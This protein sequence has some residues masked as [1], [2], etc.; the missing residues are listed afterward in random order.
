MKNIIYLSCLFLLLATAC[1]EDD[2]FEGDNSAPEPFQVTVTSRGPATADLEWNATTDPDGDSITYAVEISGRKVISG[3]KTN[4]YKLTGL[5][6]DS[7]YNGHVVAIDKRGAYTPAGF[8]ILPTPDRIL[9]TTG[10]YIDG[11]SSLDENGTVSWRFGYPVS[12]VPAVSGDTIFAGADK[13]YAAKVS[14][15]KLLWTNSDAPV[16]LRA[17]AILH[18]QHKLYYTASTKTVAVNAVTGATLWSVTRS[19]TGNIAVSNGL[20]YTVTNGH[21]YALDMSNGNLKWDFPTSGFT[22][23]PRVKDGI[24]Y[25]ASHASNNVWEGYLYAVDAVTGAAKWQ[26]KFPGQVVQPND[27]VIGS[28]TVSGNL[29]C[30]PVY[31]HPQTGVTGN[32]MA[33]NTTSGAI[34]WQ[35]PVG[36][37]I[38]L[39]DATGIYVVSGS[40]IS[41]LDKTTGAV[42]WSVAG[43][44]RSEATIADD[45]LYIFTGN[46]N[47]A[48]ISVFSTATGAKLKSI[49]F[50]LVFN[51]FILVLKGGKTYYPATSGMNPLN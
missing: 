48:A 29:V 11:L 6:A 19:G 27:G 5:H 16:Q 41:K 35:T 3:L 12:A 13:L 7:T 24:V 25:V 36:G 40:V 23:S 33:V 49:N 32:V 10:N 38:A 4:K 1:S 51:P 26:V 43:T 46:S 31:T 34:V 20:L 37:N 44:Y 18:Y 8:K 28:P 22:T 14:D 9:L 39:A 15:G 42:N 47:D 50:T 2:P 17:T 30:L 21:L 45:K